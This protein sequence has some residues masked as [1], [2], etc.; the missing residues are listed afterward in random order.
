[1]V[2]L[3]KKPE[4]RVFYRIRTNG[5]ANNEPQYLI[6]KLDGNLDPK[7]SYCLFYDFNRKLQCTCPSRKQP[8]KHTR[9]LKKFRQERQIDGPLL[10]EEQS[11]AFFAVEDID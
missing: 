7:G 5:E 2:L 10:M 9:F 11:E 1:M 6:S 3:N 8:C 4:K